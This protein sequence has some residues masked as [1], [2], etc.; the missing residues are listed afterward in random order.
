ML[1][2]IIHTCV[3]AKENPVDYLI[4]LQK[5]RRALFKS[6][7]DYEQFVLDQADYAQ[8]LELIK[9]HLVDEE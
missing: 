1:T 8:K 2:S 6:P 5:N 9:H 7:K 4:A 3:M